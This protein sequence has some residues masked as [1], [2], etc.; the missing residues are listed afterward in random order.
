MIKIQREDS[1]LLHLVFHAPASA[2]ALDLKSA[3]EL[4]RLVKAY[5]KWSG[6]VVVSSGHPSVFCSGG[7][8]VDYR[9]LRSPA[10]GLGVN[11]EI[12]RCLRAFGDWPAVKLA[13]IEGDVLGGGME[14]LAQFHF[15][16]ALPHVLLAFWQRRQGLSTGW[17]GGKAWCERQGL[18][19]RV[20]QKL[21]MEGGLLSVHEA[22]RVGLV[23]RVLSRSVV[24]D[25]VDSWSKDLARGPLSALAKWEPDTE[26]QV[27]S[28]LWPKARF[29]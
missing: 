10:A 29:L 8:L 22:R 5:K 19:A 20:L 1:T 28:K 2:N 16:W 11:R 25:E 21:L 6:V 15:R 4:A 9:K 12:T 3:R 17:G 13:V 18:P 26:T 7:N 23:D 27:F 24:W 14:W